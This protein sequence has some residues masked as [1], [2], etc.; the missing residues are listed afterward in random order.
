MGS[1]REFRELAG[2][3]R[4]G[5]GNIEDLR[6]FE[7]EAVR[8]RVNL[9]KVFSVGEQIPPRERLRKAK[10]LS[11]AAEIALSLRREPAIS[12]TLNG[13]LHA[14]KEALELVETQR[15]RFLAA[16]PKLRHRRN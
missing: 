11:K 7:R 9:E 14:L 5:R 3:L 4:A 1:I 10:V 6:L 13:A 16:H 8:L 12:A 2:C 15:E